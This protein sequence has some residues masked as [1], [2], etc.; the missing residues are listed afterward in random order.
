M[1]CISSIFLGCLLYISCNDGDVIVAELDFDNTFQEC[2]NTVF[3]KTKTNPNESLSLQITS[4]PINFETFFKEAEKDTV[5]AT[6][7][8]SFDINGTSNNFNYRTYDKDPS[9]FFCNDIPPVNLGV[10]TNSSSPTGKA[11]ITAVLIK[12]DNDGIPAELEKIMVLNPKDST[13]VLLDTDNDGI[14]NYIDEDDD[15]DNVLTIKEGAVYNEETKKLELQD[16][17]KDG[18][19]DYLDTDDDNDKV[20]TIEEEKQSQNQDPS[21][22]ITDVTANVP[23]YLNPKV[24]DTIKPTA[25]RMHTINKSLNVNLVVTKLT[26]ENLRQDEFDFG[27]LVESSKTTDTIQKRPKFIAK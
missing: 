22:D 23:D 10:I 27:T 11:T 20:L 5:A 24:T 8:L 6:Y 17:D 14:P 25:Y 12:D 15:G 21:D 9:S 19:P 3:F 16:T 2:G 1:K 18:V 7:S 4:Q 26:L 13:M